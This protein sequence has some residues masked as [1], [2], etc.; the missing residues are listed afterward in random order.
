YTGRLQRV[1]QIT[2][3]D[4]RQQLSVAALVDIDET[5]IPQRR[6]GAGVVARIACGRR[7]LGYVWLHDLIRAV[8]TWLFI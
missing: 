1:A 4:D 7:P 2:E 8:R 6:A 3:P 5:D